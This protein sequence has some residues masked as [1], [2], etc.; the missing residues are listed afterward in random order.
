MRIITFKRIKE[1]SDI[2]PDA[3]MPLCRWLV[4]III[5]ASKKVYIRFIGTHSEYEKMGC[6]NI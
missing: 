6:K 4:T 2:H 1:F 5:F 3:E